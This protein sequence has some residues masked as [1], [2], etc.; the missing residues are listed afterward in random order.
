MMGMMFRMVGEWCPEWWVPRCVFRAAWWLAFG[1]RAIF[2]GKLWRLAVLLFRS[3]WREPCSTSFLLHFFQLTTLLL[4]WQSLSL[5]QTMN[6]PSP[7]DYESLGRQLAGYS[8]SASERIRLERFNSFFGVNPIIV[9]VVWSMLIDNQMCSRSPNPVHLLWALLFLKLYDTTSN[10]A[11]LARCDEKTFRKWSWFYIES[12]ANLDSQ[13]VSRCC[14]RLSCWSMY[15]HLTSPQIRFAN[16]FIGWDGN[17][18]CLLHIDGKDFK[19]DTLN[20]LTFRQRKKWYTHKHNHFGLKYEIGSN[21]VTGDVC[22]F[23]GPVRAAI[24]DLTLFRSF[25]KPKLAPW[26]KVTGDKGYRG[27]DK[28]FTV[29]DCRSRQQERALNAVDAR[30]ETINGRLNFFR[31]MERTWRHDLK[32]HHFAFRACLTLV[33]VAQDNGHP[34]FQ[35]RGFDN[36]I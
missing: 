17:Q 16:R 21:I 14:F 5:S 31:A 30:H 36:P 32:K 26:E 10:L 23:V 27:D 25:L 34:V 12:I 1:R 28:V 15:P 35:V 7:T 22:H 6:L 24:H 8:R 33:Q 19:T 4:F 2:S 20:K 3:F 29:Y 13:V 11:A 9:S 18:E